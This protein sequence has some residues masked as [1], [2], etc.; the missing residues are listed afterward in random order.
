MRIVFFND[1]IDWPF[2]LRKVNRLGAL[3][4]RVLNRVF[5]LNLEEIK[6]EWRK[7]RNEERYDVLSSPH[8]IRMIK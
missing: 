2:T 7:L 4:N 3:D 1:R 6:G 8:M 5:Q